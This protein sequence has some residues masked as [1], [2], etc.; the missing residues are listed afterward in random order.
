MRFCD[1]PSVTFNPTLAI[2]KTRCTRFQLGNST[3]TITIAFRSSCS[4]S[5]INSRI[6]DFITHP[7]CRIHSHITGVQR[8]LHELDHSY[9]EN[10]INLLRE[11]HDISHHQH[12]QELWSQMI[13]RKMS[14]IKL[15]KFLISQR[16]TQGN[17]ER[18]I[19]TYLKLVVPSCFFQTKLE[20][21]EVRYPLV[22]CKKVFVST[23]GFDA[24]TPASIVAP[25]VV[26]LFVLL[27]TLNPIPDLNVGRGSKEQ[28]LPVLVKVT[29]TFHGIKTLIT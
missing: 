11:M 14:V 28:E 26:A 1:A 4:M 3:N 18:C 5:S 15:H 20:P 6:A 17:K 12:Q 16:L 21:L 13:I 27:M 19:H 7:S 24:A 22:I 2:H 25:H 29:L 10:Q 8:G 9:L 23:S